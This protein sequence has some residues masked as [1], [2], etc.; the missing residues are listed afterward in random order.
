MWVVEEERGRAL[1]NCITLS[2]LMTLGAQLY[3]PAKIM[4]D[5]LLGASRASFKVA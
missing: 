2:S 1:T 3:S 5:W 4:M